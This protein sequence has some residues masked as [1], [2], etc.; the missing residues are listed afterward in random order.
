MDLNSAQVSD[1]D[2]LG[3]CK[4]YFYLG[5]ALLPFLWA[6]NVFWFFKDAFVRKPEFPQQKDFR[7]FVV[8]SAIGSVIFLAGLITWLSIFTNYRASWGE[9]GDRLSFNIPTGSA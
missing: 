5:F 4:R 1:E 7:K 9:L 8:M 6:I 3:L 2:K